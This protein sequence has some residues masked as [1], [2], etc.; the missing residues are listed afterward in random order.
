M[1]FWREET[2]PTCFLMCVVGLLGHLPL[3]LPLSREMHSSTE[4]YLSFPS[5]ST[6]FSSDFFVFLFCCASI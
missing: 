6:Y 3:N 1:S 5:L 4:L 2:K